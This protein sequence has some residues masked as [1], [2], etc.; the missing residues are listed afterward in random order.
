MFSHVLSEAHE[1]A[2]QGNT[3][4]DNIFYT[5][6]FQ[7]GVDKFL[8]YPLN[9][10]ALEITDFIKKRISLLPNDYFE[11]NNGIIL[12][13]FSELIAKDDNKKEPNISIT[14]LICFLQDMLTS[15]DL[16]SSM[17]IFNEPPNLNELASKLPY[18]LLIPIQN[19]FNCIKHE[20]VDVPIPRINR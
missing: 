2:K 7:S 6:A 12:K 10:E 11:T 14:R 5:T 15:M 20:T 16:R 1:I 3:K 4:V 13:S 19:L 18:K 8:M 17:L 9:I